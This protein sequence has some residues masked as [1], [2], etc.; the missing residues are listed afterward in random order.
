[1]FTGCSLGERGLWGGH[2]CYDNAIKVPL[3]IYAPYFSKKIKFRKL[4]Y[5]LVELV[6]IFPTLVDLAGL[7]PLPKCPKNSSSIALCTEGVSLYPFFEVFSK[8]A[9]LDEVC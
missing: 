1:M 7:N 8:S 2:S 3:L 5:E 4:S 9:V 6:D